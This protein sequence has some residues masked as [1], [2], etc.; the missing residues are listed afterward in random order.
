MSF[1]VAAQEVLKVQ[2]M[3]MDIII[4]INIIIKKFGF[5]KYFSYL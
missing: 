3:K 2:V 4:M 5:L 1:T